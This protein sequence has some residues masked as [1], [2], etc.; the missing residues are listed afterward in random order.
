VGV[1]EEHTQDT[2]QGNM[3]LLVEAAVD[4]MQGTRNIRNMIQRSLT[5]PVLGNFQPAFPYI[6]VCGNL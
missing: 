2:Q 4:K 6:L 3:D 1:S 5:L